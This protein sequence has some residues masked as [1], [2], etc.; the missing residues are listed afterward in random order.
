MWQKVLKISMSEKL[1]KNFYVKENDGKFLCQRKWW[2]ISMSEKIMES[3]GKHGNNSKSQ[4]VLKN[5]Y[6]GESTKNFYV[7]ENDGK[8]LCQGKY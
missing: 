5:F 8:C 6:V 2:K 3:Q 1:P 7:R 4:K